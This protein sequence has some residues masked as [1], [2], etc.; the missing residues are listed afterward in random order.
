MRDGGRA[1]P[2]LP[3]LP[4]DDRELSPFTGWT[5][6]HWEGSADALLAG[7]RR[8]ASA[9]HASLNLP[10]GRLSREGSAMNGLEGFARTFL[11]AA[12][13]LR[14]GGG[15]APGDLVDGYAE[16]L[17]AGTDPG[18]GEAWPR[19]ASHSQAAVEAASI[20]IALYETRPWLWNR[21]TDRE[22][23]RVG[24]WL[25]AVN[26]K[27]FAFNNWL[28]FPVVVNAFLKA[29]GGEF[30]QREIERNLDTVDSFYRRDGWY[31]DGPGQS[32]DHYNSWAF[33]FYTA[34][35]SRMEGSLN[36]PGRAAVY[37]DRLKRFLVDYRCLFAG[38]GAPVHYGR[39]LLYRFGAVAAVWAGAMRGATPLSPGEARRLA[40]G[41]V[42]HFL[43]RGALR[44]GILQM[45]WHREFL[46]GVQ[47]Y[48]GPA[49]PYWASKGFLGLLI[50][51]EHEVWRA[52][53]DALAVER[54]DFSRALPGPGFL[55]SGTAAD[56]VVRLANHRSDHFPV[57]AQRLTD[58]HYRKLAYSTHTAPNVAGESARRDVDSQVTLTEGGRRIGERARIHPIVVRDR[59][60]ASFHFPG[61]W[62]A[63]PGPAPRSLRARAVR[64]LRTVLL[65]R[66]MWL[67]DWRERVETVSIALPPGEIRITHILTPERRGVR[68]GGFALAADE[69]LARRAGSAWSMV[70]RPDGLTSLVAN[71]HGYDAADTHFEEGVNA[72]G[73]YSA[74]PYLAAGDVVA[75]ERVY[76]SLV[77]LTS[78]DLDPEDAVAGVR[79][80]VDRRRVTVEC[81]DG[82]T[83]LV[84]LVEAASCDG[85][86]AES[87]F[88]EPAR[89]VRRSRDGCV[90]A[91]RG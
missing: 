73:R 33:H 78:S 75:P 50:P 68:D 7:A 87:L 76:V 12:F 89:F 56:G 54:S 48:S 74:T 62:P 40:S 60:A 38:D 91:I 37:D 23:E 17:L 36:D 39:S 9:K 71:L 19:I 47:D 57:E 85:S 77:V 11:L 34:M 16:G 13:R 84:H 66:R 2:L 35:W 30:S 53:E 14:S 42:Q 28:L 3:G 8:Y 24:T 70:Q 65:S 55:V 63:V 43:R 67:P 25:A 69:P 6:A 15:R 88:P 31:S 61:E 82:E 20:A 59:F 26:G 64:K 41:A 86:F 46:P 21:L 32:F 5:K 1:P 49:S 44:D 4:D 51:P 52:T 81:L 18:G 79:V 22:R 72:F 27:T 90:H 29:V 83:F 45:G 10:G 80:H 58:P